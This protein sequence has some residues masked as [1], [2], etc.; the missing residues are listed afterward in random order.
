MAP[1]RDAPLR[2]AQAGCL[3]ALAAVP[4]HFN[5]F[6]ARTFEPD[7]AALLLFL[8]ISAGT[9]AVVAGA[10]RR[11]PATAIGWRE[12]I[13]VAGMA[14]GLVMAVAGMLSSAPLQSLTGSYARGRGLL[15]DAACL[16]V[17]LALAALAR[18]RGAIERVVDAMLASTAAVAL[19]GAFQWLG[20]DALPWPAIPEGAI[21]SSLG[22]PRFLASVLVFGVTLGAWRVLAL[23]EPD[24]GRHRGLALA[25]IV[26]SAGL[27]LVDFRIGAAVLGAGA[28]I[29]AAP[30]RRRCHGRAGA[31]GVAA[32]MA[33]TALALAVLLASGSRAAFLGVA[34]AAIVFAL[35]AA[36]I[37]RRGRGAR[38]V[39]AVIGAVGAGLIAIDVASTLRAGTDP[40]PQFGRLAQ[41]FTIQRTARVRLEIWASIDNWAKAPAAPLLLGNGP[42]TTRT[43]L[44]PHLTPAMTA[45][46]RHGEVPDDAHNETLEHFVGS[47]LAGAL[48][49]C[50]LIFTVAA[51]A[52]QIAGNGTTRRGAIVAAGACLGVS[53]VVLVADGSWRLAGLLV[54]GSAIIACSLALTACALRAHPATGVQGPF[55]AQ[56][57]FIAALTGHF[58]EMMFNVATVASSLWMWA[59]LGLLAG[60]T[61][62]SGHADPREI[63]PAPAAALPGYA[64]TL[65]AVV[66]LTLGA[67]LLS[68]AAGLP[69]F[70]SSVALL[71]I[72]ALAGWCLAAAAPPTA[73]R[74]RGLAAIV[75]PGML[76]LLAASLID[77]V[78]RF[79][80]GALPLAVFVLLGAL[81]WRLA[82]LLPAAESDDSGAGTRMD[83]RW[84]A[85]GAGIAILACAPAM[86]YLCI[87]P[88]QADTAARKAI[89][90]ADRPLEAATSLRRAVDLEPT[91]G[92]YRIRLATLWDRAARMEPDPARR[93]LHY[94]HAHAQL[95]E[96]RRLN[97]RLPEPCVARARLLRA[98]ARM[99]ADPGFRGVLIGRA[100][101]AARCALESG[102]GDPVAWIELGAAQLAAGRDEAALTAFQRA[103]RHGPRLLKARF[104][105]LIARLELGE[106]RQVQAQL[107]AIDATS[108]AA[109]VAAAVIWARLDRAEDARAAIQRALRL[110]RA[111][112]IPMSACVT[113]WVAASAAGHLRTLHPVAAPS[114]WP[115]VESVLDAGIT[116][117]RRDGR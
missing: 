115:C 8:V 36:A 32:A 96:A 54:P 31:F 28:W 50:A 110:R 19:Y 109:L 87:R 72:A 49:Y 116:A 90:A 9:A 59:L 105:E 117:D 44:H 3:V 42:H 100:I 111:H 40:A 68:L 101:A 25:V 94:R 106:S 81:T 18:E 33:A 62:E 11:M 13:F 30:A 82:A 53:I 38:I 46:S 48:A 39:L 95:D 80:A 74:L 41:T 47:G 113:Q 24:P 43:A 60:R 77:R 15:V 17:F 102:A 67:S 2:I 84:P 98:Q 4:V 88:I 64:S 76:V 97:P 56:A 22:N 37:Q 71:V 86:Y 103:G 55:P 112:E 21:V 57:V 99:E 70:K 14:Y 63:D 1:G 26:F 114:P 104:G 61:R 92:E 65:T 7:K 34:A 16:A 93:A 58:V 20:A 75:G 35:Q 73:G 83:S 51:R 78:D 5:G 89:E 107:R 79:T 27:A 69:E 66:V 91:N 85:L 45:L 12:P 29:V 23:L 108:A 6:T 10:R 52:L